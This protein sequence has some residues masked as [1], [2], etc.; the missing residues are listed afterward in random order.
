MP[1]PPQ[2]VKDYF[3]R[4]E[5]LITSSLAAAV[6]DVLRSRPP[7]P[8]D[9]IAWHLL[10]TSVARRDADSK[11]ALSMNGVSSVEVSSPALDA[12]GE[13]RDLMREFS[14][15]L[16]VAMRGSLMLVLS[17]LEK[18]ALEHR[19]EVQHIDW[20]SEM[21]THDVDHNVA[22]WLREELAAGSPGKKENKRF[23]PTDKKKNR[24]ASRRNGM[25]IGSSMGA[26]MDPIVSAIAT[27]TMDR[28]TTE[29]T[30]RVMASMLMQSWSPPKDGDIIALDDVTG[31]HALS[32][33]GELI[34]LEH[35]LIG[36]QGVRRDTLRRFLHR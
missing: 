4:H 21:M 8:L 20:E 34:F 31:G 11:S 1:K 25:V 16:P 12:A 30:I 29:T 32:V 17:K 6:D 35:D 7:D 19:D 13:F 5:A 24:R 22:S 27:V 2:E 28:S 14:G 3:T 15:T 23:D 26:E 10:H 33:L 9:A 18:A 36:T